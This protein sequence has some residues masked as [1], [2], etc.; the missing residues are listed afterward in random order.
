[1]IKLKQA[2][3]VEG[4]YDKIR[5]S[6]FIDAMIISTDGF[7]IFKDTKKRDLIR[8]IAKKN[9]I[10]ILTDS[11]NAGR[12]IRAFVKNLVGEAEVTQVYVPQ[13]KGKER[14]KTKQSAEGFLGVEGL[15]DSVI[16]DALEK[17]GI[18]A[19]EIK[20]NTDKIT[21]ADFVMYGLSGGNDSS[22]KRKRLCAEL[23]LPDNL[24][25]N[26]LLEYLN[27]T[28]TKNEFER[29]CARCL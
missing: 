2:V 16:I 19:K 29:V 23:G 13:I 14:R 6:N 21:K 25:A 1:M 3:I 18:L 7:S 26:C 20:D 15:S 9:G 24:T 17:S 10:V 28:T 11:D 5:L 8:L 22:T 4:K 12:M 27:R